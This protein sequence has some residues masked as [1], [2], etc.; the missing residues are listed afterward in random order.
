[1]SFIDR[2]I[3]AA[4]ERGEFDDLPGAGKPIAGIDGP[5]DDL[6]WV[7]QLMEREQLSWAPATLVLRRDV[8]RALERLGEIPSERMVRSLFDDLNA[9]IRKANSQATSG[10]PTTLLPLDVDRIVDRWRLDRQSRRDT[11]P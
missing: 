1:V 11:H 7:K 3:D 6:W 5:H 9:R 8:E 2:L 4:H 10:P